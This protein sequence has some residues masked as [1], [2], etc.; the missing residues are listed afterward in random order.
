MLVRARALILAVLAV[1]LVVGLLPAPFAVAG[2][3]GP[4]ARSSVDQQLVQPIV[5]VNTSY[6]NVRS[7]PGAIYS[8]VGTLPG[9]TVLPVLGRNRDASWWQV[10]SVFGIGWV[11]AEFVIPRGDFRIVP[12]VSAPALLEQPRAAVTGRP[13][14]VYIYPDTGSS[15]LGM[16][17]M[18]SELPISGKTGDGVWWQVTTNVGLGWVLQSDVALRGDATRIPVVAPQPVFLPAPLVPVTGVPGTVPGYPGMPAPPAERPVIYVYTEHA[19]VKERPASDAG[20]IGWIDYGT[21]LE[22]QQFSD[23]GRWAL[24]VFMRNRTG[25]VLLEDVAISDPS[26]PRTQLL[27]PG[28]NLLLDLKASP[29]ANAETIGSVPAEQILYANGA[30]PDGSWYLVE[31]D[32]GTGWVP[33]SS[34]EVIRVASAQAQPPTTPGTVPTTPLTPVLG[35]PSGPGLVVPVPQRARPYVIVNTSFLNIRSGPG[36]NYTTVQTVNGGTELDLLASTPDAVWFQVQG[37]GVIGW[38][39]SEF[40]IF[41]GDFDNVPIVRYQD[42]VGVMSPVEAIVSAPINVYRGA[43]VET[44]LL[45]TA[46]AGLVLP[47]VGRTADGGWLQVQTSI[48]TGWVLASTVT[49][50]GDMSRVPLVR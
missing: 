38:V 50:R 39:N 3:A 28:P 40:V 47:V 42:A 43:G 24:V 49:V 17:L 45:G 27:Y 20:E 4:A 46:P 2:V 33:A 10:Q 19:Q 13:V 11:S 34:V 37:P 25:W 32:E 26:D 5:I 16:A 18:G 41:R 6:L 23:D 36:A 22:V 12:V 31:H 15:V 35:Q 48:G 30:T 14:N 7:G 9:G 21:R 1:I 8:I 29:A 44:G